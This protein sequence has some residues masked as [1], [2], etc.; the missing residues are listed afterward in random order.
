M[1]R[2]RIISRETPDPLRPLPRA[3]WIAS[4][5]LFFIAFVTVSS[6]PSSNDHVWFIAQILGSIGCALAAV[7]IWVI[8]RARRGR[9]KIVDHEPLGF[10]VIGPH[11]RT[12]K[13][14]R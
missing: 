5:L 1:R 10:G 6:I 3:L 12:D 4:F 7:V 2:V 9:R 8:V 13:S 11:E 14:N